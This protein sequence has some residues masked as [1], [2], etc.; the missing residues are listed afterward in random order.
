MFLL[1]GRTN[2]Y[3]GASKD[4]APPPKDIHGHEYPAYHSAH[5][6]Y[7]YKNIEIIQDLRLS[8]HSFYEIVYN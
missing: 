5:N 1:K 6:Y 2:F 3:K 4:I 7:Y 8:R